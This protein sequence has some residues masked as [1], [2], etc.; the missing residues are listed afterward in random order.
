MKRAFA[1]LLALCLI[2]GLFSGC[3]KKSGEVLYIYNW[4]EY[5]PQEVYDRFEDETGIRVIETTFSSNEEMLAKLQA[6]GTG[7]YDLVIASNYVIGAMKAEGMIQ[8]IDKSGMENLGNINPA[9]MDLPYD[10]G[11]EYSIPYMGTLTVIATNKSM[12]ADLGVTITSLNDLTNP[13]LQKNLVVPDDCR[14]VVD[15]ALKVMG[16][17]P[18]T[19]D[20]QVIASTEGWLRALKGNVR[21]YDS[22]NAKDKLIGK[23]V[24]AGL[25]YNLDAAVAYMEDPEDTEIIFVDEPYEMAID[26]FVI[27]ADAQNKA[28]AEKFIDFIHRGE[29]YKIAAEE[30]PALC[31]NTA[32]FDLMSDEYKKNPAFNVPEQYIRNAHLTGDVG[33]A[34]GYYDDVFTKMKTN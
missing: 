9:Y 20:P 26:S 27:T 31:F 16:E 32:A 14:E 3:G 8:P 2:A 33:D 12:C 24:A 11:N 1:I 5:I 15:T 21:A 18:D 17:D 7:Q 10:P 6:G 29:V 30:Y 22:D 4:T 19:Q 28:N 34:A 23:E 13:A 25:V